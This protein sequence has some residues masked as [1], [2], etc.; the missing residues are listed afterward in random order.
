MSRRTR[1]HRDAVEQA[2]RLVC[3]VVFGMAAASI[4]LGC[5]PTVEEDW[6]SPILI[7]QDDYKA[8][9]QVTSDLANRAGAGL[10]IQANT[11]CVL[12]EEMNQE[13]R[14]VAR[15]C[16]ANRISVE[17]FLALCKAVGVAYSIIQAEQIDRETAQRA[18]ND[19]PEHQCD[20]AHD[21]VH[22]D[23]PLVATTPPGPPPA[24]LTPDVDPTVAKN[25]A[26]LRPHAEEI[27]ELNSRLFGQYPDE[28]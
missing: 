10:K 22:E 15:S 5:A 9:R 23:P 7:Q 1:E 17:R 14:L 19:H 26:L 2:R 28:L 6:R 13:R 16:Q 4:L 27:G 8:W 3:G 12:A 25:V 24:I 20:D 21:S 11:F 18:A